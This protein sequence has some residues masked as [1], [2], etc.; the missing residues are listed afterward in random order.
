MKS[1]GDE[2]VAEHD[3]GFIPPQPIDGRSVSAHIRVVK[4]VVMHERCHVDHFDR[5]REHEMIASDV[6][7]SAARGD[8]T[9]QQDQ[10]RT[11]HFSAVMFDVST[12]PVD[13]GKITRKL[14]FE[15][16]FDLREGA[17]EK[18]GERGVDG[19]RINHDG[20]HRRL[21]N[22]VSIA[23]AR[24]YTSRQTEPRTL[25]PAASLSEDT[26][27]MTTMTTD[28]TQDSKP[29]ELNASNA[30]RYVL[31]EL[32]VQEPEAECDL[33]EQV[34]K[35]QRGR[36][37]QTIREDFAGTSQVAMEWVKRNERNTAVCVDLD[38]E[39]LSWAK[40]KL[41]ERLNESQQSRITFVKEDVRTA[42]PEPVDSILAM[43]FSYY[44]F[45]T[46]AGMVEYFKNVH[47]GLKEDGLFLL[48]AY[49]G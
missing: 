43:N 33:I 18:V 27:A 46:R 32:S 14:R 6:F 24:C 45:Q 4:D 17:R 42:R 44:A 19:G 41:G 15:D 11:E 10:S 31:Y 30:D 49:G 34:W 1:V 28:K 47:A 35:E 9:R 40:T 37:C 7:L 3:G 21:R 48:D 12:Q 29:Q 25:N 5:R 26:S 39:V 13:R 22:E 2:I 23:S 16:R 38:D 8:Q 36:R 20:P